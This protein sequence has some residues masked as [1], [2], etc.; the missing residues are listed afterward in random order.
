MQA[1]DVSPRA[2]LSRR[3]FLWG[4][5][6]A[7]TIRRLN[8]LAQPAAL[9]RRF[10]YAAR[11]EYCSIAPGVR[12][13]IG[14]VQV[15]IWS[16]VAWSLT[17]LAVHRDEGRA[18]R[19]RLFLVCTLSS[20]QCVFVLSFSPFCVR[21]ACCCC[22][23]CFRVGC[24]CCRLSLSW[25]FIVLL[26][27]CRCGSHRA[28]SVFFGYMSDVFFCFCVYAAS[29]VSP[30]YTFLPHGWGEQRGQDFRELAAHFEADY[31]QDMAALGVRPPDVVTRVSEFIPDVR[32]VAND[33]G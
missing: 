32:G 16:S 14:K 29:Y 27:Y 30:K 28:K 4:S 3:L 23:C 18:K 17:Q 15:Y 9:I 20:E 10:D 22:C 21:N 24:W 11:R 13:T 26:I 19:D 7:P 8:S 31:M 2:E 12:H 25:L 6:H 33:S 1:F 5:R